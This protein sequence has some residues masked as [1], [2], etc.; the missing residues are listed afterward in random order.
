MPS[1]SRR[2]LPSLT[3]ANAHFVTDRI[4]VGGDLAPAFR[5]ARQQLQDLKDAGITHIADLRDEWNDEELVRSWAPDVAYLYHPVEDAGQRIPA[6]WFE[7]LNDWVTEALSD[8]DTRVLVHCHMGVNR[9]PSAAFALLLAQGVPVRR[10]LSA[11]RGQRDVAVIDYADD[12][13]D[14]HLARTG[15]DRYARAGARRSLT[16]WRR[17]NQIDKLSVIRQ[18]RANEGGGNSWCFTLNPEG[19]A[20]LAA[21]VSDS[22]N[23]TIGLGLEVEPDELALRDEV[24]LWDAGTGDRAAGGVVGFGWIVGPPREADGANLLPVVLMGFNPSGLIPAEVLDFVAPGVGFGGRPNPTL[25]TPDQV[26]A[27]NTGL[28]VLARAGGAG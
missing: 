9:A 11:I 1:R 6:D 7:R 27:L 24:V 5:T 19:I 28:Q 13:L 16:M 12:A 4:A 25:L 22:P 18:I 15:A 2:S 21:L 23:P 3:F 26:A 10:S 17:S 8:P 20:E 14:W